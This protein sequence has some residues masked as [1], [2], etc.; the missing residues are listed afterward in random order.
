M[1]RS[2][3]TTNPFQSTPSVW[4]ET[5]CYNRIMESTKHFNPLPPYGGRRAEKLWQQTAGKFQSTPSVW[6][7]TKEETFWQMVQ[8]FQS[9]P[10]VWRETFRHHRLGRRRNISI[11]SLRMEGDDAILHKIADI[12]LFQSTPSVWRETPL[13]SVSA[14][15]SNV[16]QSTPSVWRETVFT[17]HSQTLPG[18]SI[19]SLRMEGDVK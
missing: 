15:I 1:S 10:S 18:I 6:R 2:V 13:S 9:T 3:P 14:R 7:E 16:F 19:H 8:A 17:S 5:S 4:R 11:H 12:A